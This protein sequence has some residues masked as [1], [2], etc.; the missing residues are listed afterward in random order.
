MDMDVG[1]LLV[2][3]GEVVGGCSQLVNGRLL[4]RWDESSSSLNRA[5]SIATA[6][7]AGLNIWTM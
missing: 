2:S 5:N 3:V 6:N 1:L 7:L 4:M